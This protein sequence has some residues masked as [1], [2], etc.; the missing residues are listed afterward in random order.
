MSVCACEHAT[1]ASRCVYAW[2]YIRICVFE[3]MQ[4]PSTSH[5][6][7][8]KSAVFVS[9]CTCECVTPASRCV[10][11]YTYVHMY[12]RICVFEVIQYTCTSLYSCTCVGVLY[13]TCECVKDVVSHRDTYTRACPPIHTGDA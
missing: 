9:V 13:F 3:G 4:Y 12:L 10:Y 5:V 2:T 11:A 6:L 7:S 1:P 8:N